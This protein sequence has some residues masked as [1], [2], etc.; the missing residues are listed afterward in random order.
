M[1]KMVV[2]LQDGKCVIESWA[3]FVQ[4]TCFLFES[5]CGFLDVFQK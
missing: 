1:D 3:D 5:N 4:Y 2:V